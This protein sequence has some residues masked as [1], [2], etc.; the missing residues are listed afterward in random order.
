MQITYELLEGTNDVWAVDYM[1]IQVHEQ[2]FVQFMY[3]PDYLRNSPSA[4]L[5]ITNATPLCKAMNLPFVSSNL[6]V[7]G[8]NVVATSHKVI[9]CD[10]L[11]K[12]NSGYTKGQIWRELQA[13][14]ETDKVLLIPEDPLDP[15]GHADGMVRFVDADTVLVNDYGDSDAELKDHLRHIFRKAGLEIIPLPYNPYSNKGKWDAAGIYMNYLHMQQ[16]LVVPV[17]NR[18]E[19]ETAVRLLEEVFSGQP[20]ITV[21]SRELAKEGGILNCI[22]WNIIQ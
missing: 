3:R 2:H 17:F 5:S 7:D 4:R 16:G 20:I 15:V 1:P 10:K 22:S 6:V 13:L 19:D 12:E 14:F 9:L 18:K 8:G 21:D 11:V